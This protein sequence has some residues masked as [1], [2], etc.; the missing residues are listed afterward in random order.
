MG[1]PLETEIESLEGQGKKRGLTSE[2]NDPTKSED[3]EESDRTLGGP[4]LLFLSFPASH[5]RW[6]KSCSCKEG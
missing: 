3:K 5:D 1:G 2:K 6:R 4:N